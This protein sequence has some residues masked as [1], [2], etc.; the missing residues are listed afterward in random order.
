MTIKKKID[1]NMPH[2]QNK[3]RQILKFLFLFFRT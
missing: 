3:I 2:A 1:K